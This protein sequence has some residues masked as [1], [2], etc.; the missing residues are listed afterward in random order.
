MARDKTKNSTPAKGAAG[1]S[2]EGKVKKKRFAWVPQVRDN[3]RMTKEVYPRLGWMMLGAFVVLLGIGLAI[4]FIFSNPFTFGMI[5]GSLGLLAAVFLFSRRAMSAAY[6]QV[7]DQPGGAAAVVES[8][9]GNWTTSPAVSI[10][11]NQDM[12][13]RVI[14]RPGVILV[15]E[16]P[17]SRVRHMLSSEKKRTQRFIPDTPI[18]EIQVGTADGQVPVAKL[19]KTLSKLPKSLT[20]PEVND[21]RRR[22][23]ALSQQPA[24]VPKGPVPKSAK[25]ARAQM[26]GR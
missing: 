6:K 5:G 18:L 22:L 20:P 24:A 26:R 10:T 21:V 13:H 14:G 17:D 4:G 23:D 8:M 15:S 3:Y 16:G 11:K 1:R 2:S 7:E 9:K 19:Q 12:V 25:A